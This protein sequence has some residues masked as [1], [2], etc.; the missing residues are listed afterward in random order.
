MSK[1]G[2]Y[3]Q[4]PSLQDKVILITGGAT[5]IG[6]SMVEHF[7]AQGSRVAFLDLDEPAA[8]QLI[9]SSRGAKHAPLF[10]KCDLTDIATLRSAIHQIDSKL[11][12]V[13]VLVNN[14]AR[15][16]RHKTSEI[17]PDYWDERMAVNLRHQFFATQAVVP[18]MTRE[19]GGS[20]INMSS[21]SWII[22]STGLPAY[23]TAKAGIVG[24]TRTLSRE[25]GEANIR[26]NCVLPGAIM[27]ERQRKL[28]F[29]PEYLAEVMKAQ[30]LKRELLPEDVARL[31]LFLAA[32]D[33]G[34]ITG[35][36]FIV[37]GGWV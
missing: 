4:Y 8:T 25:L 15:D 10:L 7:A 35:Q 28:W 30:A 14:A 17:S 22:P 13:N 3:A 19:G 11:G 34:S 27:T 5:G 9:E 32:D 36:N 18:G 12:P 20:I 29:T 23:V 1:T 24:L 31:V 2:R 26:V 6:A 16:D 21:I 33:S 37:D